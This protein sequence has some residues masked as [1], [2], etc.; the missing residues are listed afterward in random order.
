M[1]SLSSGTGVGGLSTIS[2]RSKK[3]LPYYL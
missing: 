3:I 2:G 1:G